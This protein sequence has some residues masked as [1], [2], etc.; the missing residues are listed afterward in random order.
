MMAENFQTIGDNFFAGRQCP[1][2]IRVDVQPQKTQDHTTGN[3]DADYDQEAVIEH[4]ISPQPAGQGNK[5]EQ[6]SQMGGQHSRFMVL[7][8]LVHPLNKRQSAKKSAQP[9]DSHRPVVG[10]GEPLKSAHG[11]YGKKIAATFS[12]QR[13]IGNGAPLLPDNTL[14]K[15]LVKG[16]GMGQAAILDSDQG[17]CPGFGA[18]AGEASQKE[19]V[20][21][22]HA[23]KLRAGIG[24]AREVNIAEKDIIFKNEDMLRAGRKSSVQA[25]QMGCKDSLFGV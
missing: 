6:N 16:I 8:H 24:K 23:L 9:V 3:Q 1:N 10:A 4:F 11:I 2:H 21:I 13:V 5:P 14:G 12:E 19:P 17:F 22:V 25:E 20:P 7:V 18:A 15:A